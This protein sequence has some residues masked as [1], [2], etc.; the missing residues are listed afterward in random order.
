MPDEILAQI[1]VG[2]ESRIEE[3]TRLV[4]IPSV[5]AKGFPASELRC[6][7][8]A[9]AALLSDSGFDDVEV[10][11]QG[12]GHPYVMGAWLGAGSDAPT[13]LLYAHYDVQPPGRDAY[14]RSPAFEPTRVMDEG[15]AGRLYGRGVVDDK[16]GIVVFAGALRAWLERGTPP[17]VNLKIVVEGEEEIG[18]IHL[19]DFLRTHHERLQADV[20]VLSDTANLATGLPSITTSLRGILNVDVRVR[21][22]D[23]P[24]HSGMWGGP[25]PDA[26][27]ALSRILGR[28]F[29]DDGSV[30]IPD[31]EADVVAP[32]RAARARME[33]LPIDEAE[34]RSDVG[35]VQSA[36]LIARG[37]EIYERL[38]YRPALSVIALEGMPIA[39]AGNQLIAEAA[40]RIGVRLAPGQDPDAMRA[41]VVPFLATNPPWG[42]EV[43]IEVEAAAAGWRME[44]EGHAF[45]AAERALRKGYDRA[46]VHIGCGGGIPFVAPF[47]E[48]LGGIPAL[49]LGLEDPICKAH[50]ENE[51]LDLADFRR[52]MRA[53][54][55]LY[56][57]IAAR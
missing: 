4:R 49:L 27:S 1:D 57:E 8:E 10:L 23:H 2:F 50:G 28:L 17:P 7:A 13:L 21:A 15:E 18:S 26:T 20:L 19:A 31:F 6:S 22:L 29:H 5:S 30:A 56:Y 53:V 11:S 24:V 34:F 36:E 51:S 14:W 39:E 25:V 38:W 47:T 32:S 44:P 3:L 37:A 42:A 16:A 54:A 41:R 45:E 12:G 48:V 40:A 52:A 33:A 46:P 55:V 9:V 35:L 43:K